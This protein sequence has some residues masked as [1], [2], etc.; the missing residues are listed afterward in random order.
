[1]LRKYFTVSLS[2]CI[3]IS[4]FSS[5]GS[6]AA[7]DSGSG[8]FTEFSAASDHTSDTASSSSG[9]SA[10]DTQ[11]D[12]P[13]DTFVSALTS[14]TDLDPDGGL[15]ID[16]KSL[17]SGIYNY[18]DGSW[19]KASE[20]A[21]T[22]GVSALYDHGII[23]ALDINGN[24]VRLSTE[25]GEIYVNS[26]KQSFRPFLLD[27]ELMLPLTL[28]KTLTGFSLFIDESEDM[29]YL[30]DIVSSSE[31]P[32]GVKIPVLMYH[33]VSDNTWGIDELFVKPAEME[34]QL[35][36]IRDNGYTA[37]TFEDLDDL[38]NI[39]KPVMLTFDDGYRDN[40]DELYPLLVEYNI[41]ATVFM[42]SGS[43]GSDKYLTAD[44]IKEMSGSG[45]VSVQSHTESHP[46]LTALGESDLK[47]EFYNSKLEIALITGKEPFVLCYPTGYNNAAVR[48]AASEYYGFGLKMKGN[49]WNTSGDPFLINRYYISRDTGIGSFAAILAG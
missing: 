34:K 47:T 32:S 22:L 31:V 35:A 12:T 28:I 44:M 18:E 48:A 5:C 29:Y 14:V 30:T 24:S 38:G 7:S 13:A 37:I 49:L 21:E 26:E 8:T 25:S 10:A 17:P 41:K 46:D 11:T 27:N 15:Y 6:S 33:A 36:Y 43:I 42:I 40:Y 9:T 1:M 3:F 45:L 20:L 23:Y 2:V 16:G 39:K 4:V 19:I